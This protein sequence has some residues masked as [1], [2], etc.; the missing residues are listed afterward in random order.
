VKSGE[1][2]FFSLSEDNLLKELIIVFRGITNVNLDP[3]GRL[4]IPVRYR[5]SVRS[6]YSYPLVVT[7]D[8]QAACLLLYPI[9]E[10]EII[11]TKLQNLS[12]FN[13]AI[14]RK[15]RLLIG[16]ATELEIDSAS[17]ILIPPLLRDYAC[18]SKEVMLVGQGKKFEL[19]DKQKWHE[20]RETWLQEESQT[21]KESIP[22]ELM[23]ISI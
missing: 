16:H 21:H 6:D 8:T 23:D 11:E 15:Q 1:K 9:K 13:E 18:L 7:I 20:G 2:W 17:R 3:K 19:W 12:S 5:D 22:Q 14:R 10:W 4:A